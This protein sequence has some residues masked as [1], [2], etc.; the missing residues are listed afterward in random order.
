MLFSCS[1]P[2]I[3]KCS[4]PTG[5]GN[6]TWNFMKV[7]PSILRNVVPR[8]GTE[9]RFQF[10]PVHVLVSVL[11]NVVPRQGTE[12]PSFFC[13]DGHC[14]LLRNVVPRQGTETSNGMFLSCTL[15]I[16]KCSSP[17][18]DG[19]TPIGERTKKHLLFRLRNVVPRQ[20]TETGASY[21]L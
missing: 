7:F 18:G 17:T 2:P 19:N 3:E 12:T 1:F 20:G 21:F 10:L 8:Q 15:L 4:S 13:Q 14:F 11:R 9:T 5:D 16:E 6:L